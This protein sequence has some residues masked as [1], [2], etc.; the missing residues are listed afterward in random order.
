ML[1]VVPFLF[2]LA[3]HRLCFGH[4]YRNWYPYFKG[5]H[6]KRDFYGVAKSPNTVQ[7]EKRLEEVEDMAEGARAALKRVDWKLLCRAYFNEVT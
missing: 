5:E 7:L 6:L 3:V 1:N 4:V 2:S